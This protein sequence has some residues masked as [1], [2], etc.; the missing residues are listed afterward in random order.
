MQAGS[1]E[2]GI[3][4]AAR[5]ADV[6]FTACLSLQQGQAFYN[7]LKSR[8]AKYDRHPDDVKIMPGVYITVGKTEEEAHQKREYLNSLVMPSAGLQ[9]LS[10]FTQIDFRGQ[11]PDSIFPDYDSYEDDPTL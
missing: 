3:E 7:K 1:S 9:Q 6:V 4:L 8:L 5:T 2:A 10:E 11:D